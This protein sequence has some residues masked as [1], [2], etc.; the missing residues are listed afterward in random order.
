V[1]LNKKYIG[2]ILEIAVKKF[3]YN[4]SFFTLIIMLSSCQVM[5]PDPPLLSQS[6]CEGPKASPPPFP[7]DPLEIPSI[8]EET[9][10]AELV[11]LG[12][13]NNPQTRKA[14]ADAR[15]AAGQLGVANSA[16]FPQLAGQW[17]INR[18]GPQNNPTQL[19][20]NPFTLYQPQITLN[21][22]LWDFGGR[23][24]AIE[25]AWQSLLAAGWNYSWSMQT[26]M[27]GIIQSYYSYLGAKA[28]LEGYRLS[29]DDAERTLQAAQALNE[30]GVNT[31]VDV[32]QA[33]A[34]YYQTKLQVVQQEGVLASSKAQ[35]SV[36]IGLSPDICFKVAKPVPRPMHL[37][38]CDMKKMFDQARCCRADLEGI[39]ATIKAQRANVEQ[40]ISQFFP[41]V[42]SQG[43]VGRTYFHNAGHD[44]LDFSQTFTLNIPIFTG[45]STVNAVRQAEAQVDST[46]ANFKNQELQALLTVVNNYYAVNTALETYENSKEGYKYSREAYEAALFSYKAGSKSIVDVIQAESQLAA[47]R[48]TFIKSEFGW[49]IAISNLVYSRGTLI[50]NE[51]SDGICTSLK[52][53]MPEDFDN[54]R[55]EEIA[56]ENA[57]ESELKSVLSGSVLSQN[58]KVSNVL[59]NIMKSKPNID[60]DNEFLLLEKTAASKI[61]FMEFLKL[62]GCEKNND[63]LPIYLGYLQNHLIQG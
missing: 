41:T 52:Q 26:V 55:I 44:D 11:D 27:F 16:W 54:L 19:R 22:L 10:L 20:S 17:I 39:K 42:Q 43:Y 23:N 21:Y 50:S 4:L 8:L 3:L 37:I 25:N 57:L 32:L 18:I 49:Y 51:P 6:P 56:E 2:F 14:W 63:T 48:A 40:Q 29:M 15:A 47:A 7:C 31:I 53:I 46:I 5:L 58:K 60:A 34:Q 45:F 33:K 35:L 1:K 38:C 36:S 9:S 28:L 61:A 59:F 62:T 13:R 24:A 30:A 12:L